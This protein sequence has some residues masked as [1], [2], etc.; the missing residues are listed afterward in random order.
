MISARNVTF[1]A[2]AAT[3][4]HDIDLSVAGGETLALV[5]PNGAGKSTLLKILS[6]E[7]QPGR[8]AVLVKGK[9]AG[10]YHPRE[11]A[12]H[13]AVL[14]QSITLTFPFTVEE[15][16]RMGAGDRRTA[17]IE[18]D[19]DEALHAVDLAGYRHRI[20]TTLSGGEQQRVHFARVLVQLACGEAEHGPGILLL[21]EPTASLDLRHQLDLLKLA[22]AKAAN[23]TVVIAVLHDLN[24]ATLFAGRIV[25]LDHG[26]VVADG[27]AAET[28]TDQ[29]LER[30][31]KVSTAVGRVPADGVPFVLPHSIGDGSRG[32]GGRTI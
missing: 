26:R 10:H 22:R 7:L 17:R 20:I 8:G 16:V 9:E 29:W 3:L 32:W 12:S 4:L 14:A 15:V 2:G 31:F 24:L 6:G 23:G 21:D 11:L 13:R 5:G 18:H 28:I 25:M 27:T 1:H 19:V 30:V